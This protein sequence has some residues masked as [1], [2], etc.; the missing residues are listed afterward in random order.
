MLKKIFPYVVSVL[1]SVAIFI[2]GFYCGIYTFTS[3]KRTTMLQDNFIQS[4]QAIGILNYLDE[5]KQ[6]QARQLLLLNLD[7]TIL[8]INAL[9]EY[10]DKQSY[11]TACNILSGIAKH[12]KDNPAR[13][14][15]YTYLLE[16]Q[17]SQDIRKEVTLILHKWESCRKQ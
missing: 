9:A 12:R 5:G 14:A 10:A 13:Y 3:L 15:E 7:A 16:N 11:E 6:E 1:M 8:G 4:T 2:G 17:Q